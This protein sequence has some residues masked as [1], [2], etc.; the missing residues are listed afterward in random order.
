MRK[1]L[2]MSLAAALL[3]APMTE[4]VEVVQGQIPVTRLDVARNGDKLLL[5]MD[6]D[7]SGMKLG[8]DRQLTITPVLQNA[9]STESVVF[10]PFIL[11]GHNLYF[12]HM[13]DEDLAGAALYR[14]GRQENIRYHAQTADAAWMD[15]ALLKINY[16]FGG[17]C[18]K[19]IA[20]G[21][22]PIAPLKTPRFK[23]EFRYLSP[24][25]DSVKTREL[26]KRSYID[27]PLDKIEIYPDYRRNPIE[28]AA[29]VNTIDSVR[30]DKDITI[31]SI[32][33]KGFASPEGRYDHNTWLAQNRT[34]ALKGYV[35][36]LYSFAPDFI[37]TSYESE[38]WE[39][40]REYV[41]KSSMKNREGILAIIDS[42]MAPDPK[43]ARIKKEYPEEYAFLLA[44]VYPGLRHSDYKIDYTIRSFTSL[45]D[46][47]RV[48][49]TEPQKLSLSEFYRAAQS[50]TPGSPEY[51]EVFE[52]A[53]RMYPNDPVANLNAANTAM[54]RGDYGAAERYL[55]KTD[56]DDP[57]AIYARGIL[58]ALRENYE[59]SL[60]YFERAARLKVADAPAAI[61]NVKEIIEFRSGT[62]QT[63][64]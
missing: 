19:V 26:K 33:I 40:L 14:E 47:L 55:S 15:D 16:E 39:G 18:K 42:D 9:D 63:L 32:S 56:A 23:P 52:T 25:G 53:V 54:G 8:R 27:F 62:P 36:R 38:D 49:K 59:G 50:M 5:D 4:A 51:N 45:E 34:Q 35:E 61:E 48:L 13:R 43:N 37:S 6:L 57:S 64:K 3:A 58:E 44:T 11:A 22:D 29:I 7:V 31:T 41:D 21:M 2:L 10:A 12:K 60:K 17:C 24:V 28:L 30:D 46:I 20:R 1:I